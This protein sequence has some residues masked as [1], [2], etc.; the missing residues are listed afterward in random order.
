MYIGLKGKLTLA[1]VAVTLMTSAVTLYVV[2]T[3]GAVAE[4]YDDVANRVQPAKTNMAEAMGGLYRQS[5]AVRGYLVLK[6]DSFH[7]E[8]QRADAVVDQEMGKLTERVKDADLQ[9]GAEDIRG[10]SHRY[11]IAAEQAMKLADQG[12]HTGA[13]AYLRTEAT[14]LVDEAWLKAGEMRRR[15]DTISQTA[16]DQA[17]STSQFAQRTAY[18]AMA[19]GLLAGLALGLFIARAIARPVAQ[20]A[21][22]ARLIAVGDLTVPPL[23]V[24]TKDEVGQ[25]SGAFNAMVQNLRELIGQVSGSADSALQAS[26]ALAATSGQSAGGAQGTAQAVTQVAAGAAEQSSAADEMKST[27]EQLL[28]TIQQVASASQETAAE[29]QEAANLTSEVRSA[30]GRVVEH[31]Q[32]ITEHNMQAL[33]TARSGAGSSEKAAAGMEHIRQVVDQAAAHIHDLEALSDKVGDITQIISEIAEQTNLLALNAAIEA[34]RA[35]EHGR[36]FAVV[37]DEVRKLAERSASSARDI[38]G[39]INDIQSKTTQVVSA[40]DAG[41]A[42]TERGT[43][44]SAE[45]GQGLRKIMNGV[46]QTARDVEVIAAL[47]REAQ[48]KM[49]LAAQAIQGVAAVMEENSAATEEMAAG[50]GQM[51]GLVVRV[52]AISQENAAAAAQVSANVEAFT[53]ASEEVSA[54]AQQLSAVAG[55]LKEQVSTFKV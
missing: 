40:M 10:L 11:T 28:Q 25:M 39:L 18:G 3:L 15:L 36:G 32:E 46:E 21:A 17:T 16:I 44:L 54:S 41:R 5:A 43:Q 42:E 2:S 24:K 52:A 20:V 34:A 9:A 38:A 30:I 1:F 8:L 29:M 37:A 13:A 22:T 47:A 4:R 33:Q 35:G 49:G 45:A 50:A 14:P 31:A 23:R 27:T 51:Q 55:G 6:D 26:Q 7:S 48:E 12:D 19:A 53:A